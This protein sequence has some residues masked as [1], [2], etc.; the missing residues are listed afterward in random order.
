MNALVQTESGLLGSEEAV[1]N[2]SLSEK[3][4]LLVV[5]D[6]HG[7]YEVFEA[8]MKE[9]G[10]QCDALIF[11][12]DGMWDIVQYLEKA[13]AK[14]VLMK[15]LP[16]VIAFVAGNGDGDKYLINFSALSAN[17]FYLENSESFIVVP[18]RQILHASG[19]SILIVHGHRHSVDVSRD[20]L[21]ASARDINCSIAVFGHTHISLA[22]QKTNVLA[23][24]PGSPTRP[25]GS[26]VPSFAILKLDSATS[27]PITEFYKVS[28]GIRGNFYFEKLKELT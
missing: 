16:P 26:S 6:T 28:K 18:R 10:S 19:H 5:S 8:I 14:T 23:L 20:V 17:S 9:W 15:T 21:V 25:R 4:R 11:S 12:G 1:R 27:I 24:N 3:S 7:H 22:E 2:L 13:Q